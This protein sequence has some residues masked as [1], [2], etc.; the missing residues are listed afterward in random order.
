MVAGDKG[1]LVRMRADVATG[2]GEM[3]EAA[4]KTQRP[5]SV[6]PQREKGIRP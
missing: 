1:G 3:V 4:V 2:S 6:D 5:V